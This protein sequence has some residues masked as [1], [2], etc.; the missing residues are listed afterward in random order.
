[1]TIQDYRR[2]LGW[3]Q[4]ELA[5]RARL[6]SNTV[7][8]AENGELVSGSTAVAIAEAFSKALDQSILVHQIDGLVVDV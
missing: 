8:K 5:R 1:M 4:S 3:T 6:T 2:R 7:R